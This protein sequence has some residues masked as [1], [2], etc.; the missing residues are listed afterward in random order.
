MEVVNIPTIRVDFTSENILPDGNVF[1]KIGEHN[2]SVLEITPPAEMSANENIALYCVAFEVGRTFVKTV[3][4]SKMIAKADTINVSLWQ[5]T[6]VGEH[7]KFQLEAYDGENNLLVKSQLVEGVFLLSVSGVQSAG[8][9]GCNGMAASVAANS[10][11]RHTHENADV[12]EKL[13]DD[14]GTLTYNGE[15]IGSSGT[16]ERP[17]AEYVYDFYD[18]YRLIN[19]GSSTLTLYIMRE[20]ATD[21]EKALVGKE[22]ADIEFERSTG[23]RVSVKNVSEVDFLPCFSVLNHI[24]AATIDG[25][26]N[27]VLASLYCPISNWLKAEITNILLSKIRITYYTY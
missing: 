16:T 3:V 14:N 8:D 9:Y 5:Q 1:G 10:K 21:E 7:V 12:L 4:R 24:V 23:E 2:A 19:E 13:A 25:T 11:A 20:E 6:T 26:E 27:I 15:A 22:I 18:D 17:T